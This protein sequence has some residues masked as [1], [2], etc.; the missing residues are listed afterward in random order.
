MEEFIEKLRKALGIPGPGEMPANIK[1]ALETVLYLGIASAFGMVIRWMEKMLAFTED[2]LPNGWFWETAVV[3]A[4]AAGAFVFVRR[5]DSFKNRRL[6]LPAKFTK[7]FAAQGKIYAI[8][9]VISAL[10]IAGGA[11]YVLATCE[12]ERS[13]LLLRITAG[14]GLAS[15]LILPLLLV[16]AVNGLIPVKW[17]EPLSAIPIAWATVW[18]ICCYQTNSINSIVADY[19][20]EIVA[21]CVLMNSFFRLAG[22]FYASFDPN[23]TMFWTMFGAFMSI[24]C[25][26]DERSMGLQLMFA[27]IAVYLSLMTWIFAMNLQSSETPDSI[28]IDDGFERM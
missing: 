17:R 20:L 4:V 14:C 26:A 3:V 8:I 11:I 23:K 5:V 22:I 16:S 7:A 18:L 9:E 27:G 13:V 15:A 21:L 2:G 28:A 12:L 6:Y 25:L 10:L 1:V 19:G 24:M